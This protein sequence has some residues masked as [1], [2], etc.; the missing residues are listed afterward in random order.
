MLV[1]LFLVAYELARNESISIGTLANQGIETLQTSNLSYIGENP[2]QTIAKA[3]LR[4]EELSEE[5]YFILDAIYTFRVADIS[6]MRVIQ[7]TGDFNVE[8]FI[9]TMAPIH[10]QEIAS[11]IPGRAWLGQ[12]MDSLPEVLQPHAK[13]EIAKPSKS[14]R[15]E[16]SGFIWRT[17]KMAK[18][19]G[20][21]RQ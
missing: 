12:G 5:E 3:C 4:P 1:G 7:F 20:N 21:G 15:R 13:A 19:V 17:Q 2:A 14:C 16:M 6:K 18:D 8:P 9:E 10:A 11:T